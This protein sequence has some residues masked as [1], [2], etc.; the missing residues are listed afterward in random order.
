VAFRVVT[1]AELRRE[2]LLEAE[3][4][5]EPV[6]SICQRFGISRQTYYRYRRRLLFEGLAGLEDKSRKPHHSPGRMD[7]QIEMEIC[8]LRKTHPRWGARRIHAELTRAGIQAPAVSSIHQALRRNHLVATQPPRRRKAFKRFQREIAND[9]WQIDATQVGLVTRKKAWVLDMIDDHSRYLLSALASPAPTVEAAWDCFEEAA[10]R[11]GLPRQVLSDN[12]L[13]FTGRLH[14]V[15]VEFERNLKELDV[16]LI[17]AGPYHPQTLGKLERFHKT[18]KLW[19]ADEGPA[20]DTAHL[21]E[22]LDGFRHH[23]NTERP[24]QGIENMTPIERFGH[25][26]PASEALAGAVSSGFD[27]NGEPVYPPRS[28]VRLVSTSGDLAFRNKVVNVGRRYARARVRLIEI[29]GLT[30][31][32]YAEELIRTLRIDPNTHYQRRKGVPQ[33][34]SVT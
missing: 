20:E 24:H 18:L 1:M 12:G 4:T 23:Y 13:C 5:G 32:Y 9:L 28:I 2:V 22:L 30:H 7:P 8:R 29:G 31:I 34:T 10:S 3:R 11:Y 6:N 14:G 21:Q 19:L 15:Q 27:P 16:E 17:N 33:L 25:V 26:D